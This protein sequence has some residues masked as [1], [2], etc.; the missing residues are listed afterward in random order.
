M[1][2]TETLFIVSSPNQNLVREG[3][4]GLAQLT[5]VQGVQH[6]VLIDIHHLA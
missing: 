4:W 2:S 6:E 5:A 1:L 3:K